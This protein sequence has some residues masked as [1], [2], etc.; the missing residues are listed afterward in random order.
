MSNWIGI[1]IRGNLPTDLITL[2]I[3]PHT[4]VCLYAWGKF[5]LLSSKKIQ[6]LHKWRI[7][8]WKR[9]NAEWWQNEN[10]RVLKDNLR[11]LVVLHSS[12]RCSP[13][14]FCSTAWDQLTPDLENLD[15]S[16]DENNSSCVGYNTFICLLTL[17]SW[18]LSSTC[19]KTTGRLR[20]AGPSGHPSIW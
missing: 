3:H 7:I 14:P 19:A 10:R 11:K 17:S 1:C 8:P 4:P 12:G 16:R 18:R 2:R 5:V 13:Q 20:P 15:V 9:K 6:G